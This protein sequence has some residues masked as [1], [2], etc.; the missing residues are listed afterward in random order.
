MKIHL[1]ESSTNQSS[2]H[3]FG[4]L[5]STGSLHS[6]YL[7][8]KKAMKVTPEVHLP[9]SFNIMRYNLWNEREHME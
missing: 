4:P 3:I 8:N 1:Y 2:L 6:S 9:V 7:V 5:L